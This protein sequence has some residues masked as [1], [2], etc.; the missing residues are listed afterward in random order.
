[1]TKDNLTT[2]FSLV[3]ASDAMKNAIQNISAN[4]LSFESVWDIA[5]AIAVGLWGYFT[6][7]S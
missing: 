5:G 2:I 7:K 1:M 6:N 3:F 4:G